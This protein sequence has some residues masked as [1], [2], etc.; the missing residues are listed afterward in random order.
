MRSVA[1]RKARL[2]DFQRQRRILSNART[3]ALALL[4]QL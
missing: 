3:T 2:L 1:A 4:P